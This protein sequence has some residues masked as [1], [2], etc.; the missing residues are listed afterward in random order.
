MLVAYKLPVLVDTS[1]F[2]RILSVVGILII[3]AGIFETQGLGLFVRQ[4]DL[5]QFGD[6][7][8]DEC[9]LIVGRHIF[10]VAPNGSQ[11]NVETGIDGAYLFRVERNHTVDSSEIQFSVRLLAGGGVVELVD[12]QSVG[13]GI[14]VN[15]S[16]LGIDTTK[17]VSG[18]YPNITHLI[19]NDTFDGVGSQL[20]FT[21]KGD[22]ATVAV[23][24]IKPVVVC[25]YPYPLM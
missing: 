22:N 11:C 21:V 23:R 7:G 17:S 25:T 4:G 19:F 13:R 24:Y 3:Q 12:G 1:H 6:R 8:R 15:A 16:C 18:T 2:H 5:C 20:F 10:A 9:F 14:S